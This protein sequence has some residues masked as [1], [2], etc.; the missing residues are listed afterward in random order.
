MGQAL[1]FFRLQQV[2][3]QLDHSQSRLKAIESEIQDDSQLMCTTQVATDAAALFT[4]AEQDQKRLELEIQSLRIKMDQ[5]NSG[6]YGG[7]VHNP[8]ELQDLQNDLSSQ[9]RHL[10]TLE[11]QLFQAMM[12]LEEAEKSHQ[13]AHQDLLDAQAARESQIKILDAEH[14]ALNRDIEKTML[15]RSA[16]L[17]SLN[18][19]EIELYQTLRTRHRGLAVVEIREN[20]C[21]ACGSTLTMAHI[22]ATRS[23]G[24]ISLCPTCGRILY[25]N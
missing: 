12:N 8:K 4:Q 6:L 11:D 7:K 21:G 9:K 18:E 16:I 13:R 5:I 14:A 22:Q 24:Q 15:E 10:N 23:P 2:D 19:K 1:T 20:T 17:E 25:G 3:N